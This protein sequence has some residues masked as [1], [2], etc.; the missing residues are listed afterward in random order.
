MAAERAT[1]EKPLGGSDQARFPRQD[2]WFGSKNSQG[3]KGRQECTTQRPSSRS[4]DSRQR[5]NRSSLPVPAVAPPDPGIALSESQAVKKWLEEISK[6]LFRVRY[7]PRSN[8]ASQMHESLHGAGIDRDVLH[9]RGRRSGARDHLPQSCMGGI[10]LAENAGGRIDTV[11]REFQL[12]NRQA[13]QQFGIDNV[14]DSVRRDV[15]KKPDEKATTSTRCS[16]RPTSSTAASIRRGC[17]G[18]PS[19][20]RRRRGSFPSRGIGNSRT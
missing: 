10:Y 18:V 16:L 8:F 4:P 7:S 9:V 2:S 11:H 1:F 20:S 6:L 5:W 17:R 13:I 12:S 19:T 3:D 14:S 15:E